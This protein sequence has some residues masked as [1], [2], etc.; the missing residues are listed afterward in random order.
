MELSIF[1]KSQ[2]GQKA[3]SLQK[4]DP[5]FDS[6]R[7][8][9]HLTRKNA[10]DLPEVSELDLMRHFSKLSQRNFGI[11]VNFYPLGS[12]TMKY[13]PRINEK[14]A[15]LHPFAA[16]HPL[17]PK[18]L[19]EGNRLLMEDLLQKLCALCGMDG[20]TL[21]PNAGA[22]G[23]FA[24]LHMILGYLRS[25]GEE[26]DEVLIPDSAHGTNP[27][28]SAMAGM[29]TVTLKTGPDG[30]IDLEELKSK[31]SSRT[32]ALMLTNP[33]TLGLF[34]EKIVEIQKLVHGKG[35]LL[36]YDG[37]N[38]NALMGV[39]MPGAMGFDV[40]H[41][42]LHK[43]FS[44][45]HGG[46]GPGAGPVLCKKHLIPFIPK[47][48]TFHG[49][50]TILVRAYLYFILHGFYGL[51]RVSEMAILNANYLKHHIGKLLKVPYDKPC[52]HEF[53]VQAD[54]FAPQVTALDLAKRLIDFGIHPPTIYF[55]QIVKECML[56]EPT[57]SE[58]KATLDRFID[59][60]RVICEEAERDPGAL[61]EAPF[62]TEVSR[63]DEAAA[64]RNPR[65]TC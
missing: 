49:N 30:D 43:T 28:T 62:T 26:R 11:D 63:L 21:A 47:T 3:Y 16:S 15:S 35:A 31:L 2:K 22:Q 48:A 19:V 58:S 33:S 51:R 1:K 7:P 37:A 64:A 20:G 59:V 24:G 8:P 6:F 23:E 55:P 38:L 45:P 25:K 12:C 9:E 52:M 32:A 56:I 61:K 54:R 10:P 14:A 13:N 27:A 46:G 44:T 57:E 60:M 40:M 5:S 4:S 53:V 34:S 41:L 36:Y 17:A 29:K 42:N 39:V 50:F 18:E 65:L